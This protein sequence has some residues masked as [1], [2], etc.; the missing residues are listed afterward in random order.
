MTK[1]FYLYVTYWIVTW[2]GVELTGLLALNHNH[3]TEYLYLLAVHMGSFA[4]ATLLWARKIEE[5]R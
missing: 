3:V 1:K 2:G 5:N 4:L